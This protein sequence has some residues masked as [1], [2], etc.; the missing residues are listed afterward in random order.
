MPDPHASLNE[1]QDRSAENIRAATAA[2]DA[3][4]PRPKTIWVAATDAS[5]P[6][7]YGSDYIT[8]TAHEVPADDVFIAR[9]IR[10]GS[11]RK[12]DAVTA[13]EEAPRPAPQPDTSLQAEP[14]RIARHSEA[15]PQVDRRR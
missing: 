7:K 13:K 15:D 5:I 3:G 2:A 1:A 8:E 11:L 12:T 9:R 6:V 4:R 14:T 10:D